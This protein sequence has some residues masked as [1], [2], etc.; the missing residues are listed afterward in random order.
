MPALY[1]QSYRNQYSNK[2]DYPL[3]TILTD[4]FTT[5]GA[6]SD[7]ELLDKESALR[8]RIFEIQEPLDTLYQEVDDL[9]ELATASDSP[10]TVKQLVGLGLQLIKNMNDYEK[11]RGEWLARPNPE[12]TWDNFKLHFTEAYVHLLR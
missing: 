4:L 11:A 7:E 3:T 2:I 10:Y 12:K 5:Y 6:I 8:S 9:Q 1:L